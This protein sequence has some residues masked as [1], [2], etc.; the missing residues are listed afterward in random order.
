MTDYVATRWYRAPE[1]ILTWE[2]YTKAID[3]WA[4]GCIFAELVGRQPLFPG[5]DSQNQIELIIDIVGFPGDNIL[6]KIRNPKA[7]SY[8]EKL[9][10][11][12]PR[13]LSILLPGTSKTAISF[14]DKLLGF[15]PS[16]RMCC[17]DALAHPYLE[18]LHCP[19]DEPVG[20]P[21]SKLEFDFENHF[22]S[23]PEYR[24]LILDEINR[25]GMA[26]ND[27]TNHKAVEDEGKSRS[28]SSSSNDSKSSSAATNLSEGAGLTA[29]GQR[30]RK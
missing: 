18:S 20:T 5:L 8:L 2:N 24:D 7:K 3:M 1:V 19:D 26:S 12:L 9:P 6:S 23:A 16:Q 21:L 30:S 11:T 14:L 17:E 29:E 4:T 28:E 27:R 15:D 13:D 25:F 10:R 22:C